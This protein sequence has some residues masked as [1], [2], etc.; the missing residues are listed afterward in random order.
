[1]AAAASVVVVVVAAKVL[2]AELGLVVFGLAV[3][4]AS[5]LAA[6]LVA[7]LVAALVVGAASPSSVLVD[8]ALLPGPSLDL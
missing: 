3:D 7:D 2:V 6:D 1:M 5:D 4:L 8:L